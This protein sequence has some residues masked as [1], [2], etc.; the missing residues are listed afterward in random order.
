MPV[1]KDFRRFK[2][3]SVRIDRCGR[4][5]GR[6][7]YWKLY[8]IE[9]SWRIII[10]SVLSV[11]ISPTWWAVAV[12]PKKQ[13]TLTSFRN[14]YLNNPLHA[15]PGH[16]DIYLFF[17]SDL[18]KMLADY[19]NLFITV[20]SDID[21]WIVRLETIRLPRNL[22]GHMNYPNTYDRQR[23]DTTYA[24]LPGAFAQLNQNGITVLIP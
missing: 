8:A 3:Q 14:Q 19:R 16:H 23:I 6:N 10:H 13:R 1:P 21:Q 22:V 24:S 2:Y 7:S 15:S 17:L 20:L 4:S 18:T 11:Q 9:N 12:G 5:I